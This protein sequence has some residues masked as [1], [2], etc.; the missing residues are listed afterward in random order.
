MTDTAQLSSCQELISK[1]NILVLATQ[2]KDGVHTSLMA[3]ANSADCREIYMVSGK[4]SQKW[5]NLLQNPQVSLLIDDREGKI[6]GKRHKIKAL[7][8]KGTFS[9][10]A[11]ETEI[12]MITDAIAETAPSIAAVFSGPG[13]SI[14]RISLES[15]Q[16]L[17][18]P[19]DSF[20]IEL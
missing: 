17:N 7:T 14:I 19:Q 20:Y 6:P 15:F 1:Q 13:N 16:M 5:Q 3:Y 11:S 4:G 9:P 8:V 2:G 12:K 10:V 18:G